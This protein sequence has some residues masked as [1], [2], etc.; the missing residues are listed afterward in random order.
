[1]V[2]SRRT[3]VDHALGLLR[4]RRLDAPPVVD[5]EAA[6]ELINRPIA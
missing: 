6:L 3:A 4:K 1:L 5:V 2:E